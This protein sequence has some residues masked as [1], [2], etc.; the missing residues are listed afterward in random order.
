[1]AKQPLFE[2]IKMSIK[3]QIDDE[4]SLLRHLEQVDRQ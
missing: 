3:K 4:W 1:M 2:D